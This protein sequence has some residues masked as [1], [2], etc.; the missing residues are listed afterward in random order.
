M[1][2]GFFRR[3]QKVVLI[4]MVLLM[5]AFLLPSSIRGCFQRDPRKFVVGT[6]GDTKITAGMRQ[7][8]EAEMRLLRESS[9]A[10]G[11]FPPRRFGE[12]EFFIFLHD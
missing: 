6:V 11:T 4:I 8:A 10:L 12:D 7:A 9:L 3:R 5:V 1:A 2:L